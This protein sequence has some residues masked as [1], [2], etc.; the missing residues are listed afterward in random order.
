MLLDSREI[1]QIIVYVPLEL[2]HSSYLM[3]S[4]QEFSKKNQINL[5]Y[6]SNPFSSKGRIEVS[7]DELIK[8]THSYLKVVFVRL[9]VK[10]NSS[11]LLAFDFHDSNAFF[12]KEA[13]EK[14]DFYIKRT[15]TEQEVKLISENYSKRIYPMGLPFMLK[16]DKISH[17]DKIKILHLKELLKQSFK[18]DRFMFKHVVNS[19]YR[20][21]TIWHSFT[22]TRKLSDFEILIK[23][24]N[25]TSVF[26]QKRFFPN[27]INEDTQL[28][29]QQRIAIVR[30]LKKDF[31]KYF[32]GGIKEDK[33]LPE[34]FKDCA[35]SVEGS[36]NQFLKA[37]QECG[38]CIYTRGLGNSIGWT[39]PEFMSQGKAIIAE[40]QKVIFPQPLIH[41][42]HLLYFDTFEELNDLI[43]Q[44]IDQPELVKELSKESR[45]YYD[46]FISP[47]VFLENIL[48]QM[49][50]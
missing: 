26:Y 35:S 16:P 9:N 10:D 41:G 44:L 30:L 21:K 24:K 27:Q 20:H 29:H 6:K 36:Q 31:Q 1:N 37:M 32:V 45:S 5:V 42:K 28:V 22:S 15:Y 46:E 12:S 39:L 40:K 23:A 34:K 18:L 2:S 11:K 47:K 43:Q 3:T 7:G 38:I 33:N 25:L 8:T 17:P 50:A 4:M 48:I 19:F 14:A 13:L 49:N